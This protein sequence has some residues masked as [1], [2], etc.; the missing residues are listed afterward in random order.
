[1]QWLSEIISDR[2]WRRLETPLIEIFVHLIVTV[3]SILSIAAIELLL[4]AVGLDG[5]QLP[6]TEV[7]LSSWMFWLE[8][9][10][11]TAIIGVGIA[12]ATVA[13]VRS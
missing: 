7:S 11:A 3:L 5:R 13:L 12:K 2:V 9:F 1:M 4:R 6:G 10:A 8:I